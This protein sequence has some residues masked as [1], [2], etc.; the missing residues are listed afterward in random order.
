MASS[1]FCSRCS[2]A[3][4]EA[5]LQGVPFGRLNDPVGGPTERGL[6]LIPFAHAHGRAEAYLLAFMR[7]VWAEGLDAGS[8]RGLRAIV[9][10]AGLPWEEA[11][12]ALAD[13]GWR[14]LAERNRQDLLDLGLWGVPSLHV[15]GTATWGQDRLWQV[16]E[17][18]AAIAHTRESR[19]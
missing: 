14:L 13:E 8:D 9:E 6:S 16:R 4:R 1:P 15:A 3:A 11:R 5:R 18:L 12:A 17:A 7:G 19:P 10:R 2:C